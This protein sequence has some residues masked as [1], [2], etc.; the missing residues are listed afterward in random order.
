[1][2]GFKG[3][4][5]LVLVAALA[6]F[7]VVGVSLSVAS[8]GAADRSTLVVLDEVIAPG[9]DTDGLNV[10]SQ[11]SQQIIVNLMEPLLAYPSRKVGDI[12]RPIYKVGPSGFQPRLATSWSKRGLV[13]TFRL[14]KGVKSCA[15][16][17]FTADDVIYTW[18]RAISVSGAAPVSW[19]MGNVSGVLPL[20]P[21]QPN[22]K[23]S[24]KRLRGEVTK[25]NDYTIRIKQLH[26]NELFPR[27]LEIFALWPFDSKE[28]KKHATPA[29]PWS[30]KWADT[31]A[32]PGLGFGPYCL[33]NWNKGSEI[34][35]TA[36]PNYYRGQPQFKRVII[37]A[38]PSTANRVAT[39]VSGQAD[40]A[41]QLSPQQYASVAKGSEAKV[42]SWQNNI[43]LM[44]GMNYKF[45]PWNSARNRLLRQAIAYAIPYDEIIKQ[46]YLGGARRWHGLCESS[47]AGFVP[48]PR[49]ETNLAKAKQLLAQ[50]GFPNGEGLPA[51]GLT[52]NFPVERSAWLQPI[53]NRIRTSLGQI[54][55]NINLAPIS[56][57]E[58]TSR[59]LTKGDMP[60]F[61]E[62]AARPLAPDVGYCALLWYVS[63]ENGGLETD[64]QYNNP[65]F[66]A[67]Y[68]RSASTV[69]PARS[70]LLR[71]MQQ[72]LITDLP[73]IPIAEVASQVA[74]RKDIT[75][76]Q[77]DEF[78]R[79]YFW[80]LKTK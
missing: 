60:M 49:Y 42:L 14:R 36:N 18:Q 66:D 31:V 8:H 11:T 55:V 61:M 65:K 43:V 33:A 17:T 41:T 32:M 78:D 12:L 62:D 63:K 16:N 75:N 9:L 29:D 53:L 6:S 37:R 77:G 4:R 38:V 52:V 15:G 24:D 64:S 57:S 10:G 70:A 27:I 22:A 7:A 34:T 74:V 72:I 19:F 5:L 26:P 76:W 35:L 54:G 67:R 59:R 39:I 51:A 20:A 45:S 47:Y 30:H 44:L 58:Y 50:A 23:A 40:I 69:G 56:T 71:Q 21:V 68:K 46:D 48:F 28:M 2:K 13:W 73:K 79:A 80:T 3:R 25:V 1:M